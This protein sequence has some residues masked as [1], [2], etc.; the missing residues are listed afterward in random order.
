MCAHLNSLV[1]GPQVKSTDHLP[2]LSTAVKLFFPSPPTA[3]LRPCGETMRE[4]R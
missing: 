1:S 4:V 2:I 3:A